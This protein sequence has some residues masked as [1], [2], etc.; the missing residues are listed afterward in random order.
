MADI[1]A[2]NIGDFLVVGR[3]NGRFVKGFMGPNG[4]NGTDGRKH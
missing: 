3:K 1:Q 2:D 4:K